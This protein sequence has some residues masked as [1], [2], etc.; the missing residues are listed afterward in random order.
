ME[1]ISNNQA[2]LLGRAGDEVQ[3]S[4][5]NHG[6]N[7][8]VFPLE[9][10]RLSGTEDIL[11]VVVSEDLLSACPVTVGEDYL[12]TGEVRSFNNRTGVGSRL[13]ITYFARTMVP[14]QGDHDNQL[15]LRGALCK[16]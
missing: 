12:V 2:L 9:V 8:Y 16:M 5:M 10:E 6:V 7:Y 14:A 3:L 15:E 13:V 4:H 11:N 1:I